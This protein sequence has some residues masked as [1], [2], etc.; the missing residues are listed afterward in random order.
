MLYAKRTI[1]KGA[2]QPDIYGGPSIRTTLDID[3]DVLAL[4]RV[5]REHVSIGRVISQ[6]ARSALQRPSVATTTCNGL[7]ELPNV[8]TTGTVPEL[9][10]QMRDEA[11]WW[12]ICL[13]S[14]Y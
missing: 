14:T 2:K 9:V 5:D 7:P 11:P 3:Y 8:H 12:R 4:A 10:N 13:R 1:L 6:L